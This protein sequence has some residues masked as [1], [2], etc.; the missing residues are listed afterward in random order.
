MLLARVLSGEREERGGEKGEHEY[1][2]EVA[3]RQ[4]PEEFG[5]E[6]KKIG[7]PREAEDGGKPVRHARGDFGILQQVDDDAEQAED[8]AR[9]D[10][11]A[12]IEGAGTGFAFVLFLGGS[13]ND[14]PDQADVERGRRGAE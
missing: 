2:E 6:G 10:E 5:A 8:T 4:W 7:T 3:Y 11:P 1:A 9:G 14:H 12:G 13:V